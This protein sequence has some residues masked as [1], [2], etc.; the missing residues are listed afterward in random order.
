[1]AV[2]NTAAWGKALWPG[3][4]KWYGQ[5]YDEFSVEWDQL[6]EKNKGTKHQEEDVGTVGL[7][8]A[9]VKAE[10]ESF[11]YES[12]MQGF[13]TRYTPVVLGLGMIITAETI[14]DD[15]YNVTAPK[16]ARQLAFSMRQT[17]EVRGANIYNR[18]FNSS[19]TYGDGKEMLAD[20]HPNVSGGTWANELATAADLSENSLEQACIDIMKFTN[21]KGL[22]IS[23]IPQ[24]LHIPVDLTFEVERI[25]KS[26]LRVGTSDNDLNALKYMGKFPGGVK[27]NHYFDDTDAWFIRTNVKDGPK[28]FE[29]W[30]DN[31]ETD[32]DFDSKNVKYI[33]YGRYAFGMTDPR[34]VFGSPGA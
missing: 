31:F 34:S 12:T 27:V 24:T 28:Y 6:F 30:A 5:E 16:Q 11:A 10:G 21:D 22:R 13:I 17:K 15:M 7:G 20:D 18:A 19:Y 29:W 33:A 25:L 32:N 26:P 1:M 2:I 14:T 23:V 3:V 9:K 4:N 8:Y